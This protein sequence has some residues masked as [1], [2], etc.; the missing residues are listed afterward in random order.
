MELETAEIP[1]CTN[2][3]DVARDGIEAKEKLKGKFY[4]LMVL[5]I[6]LPLSSD[7]DPDPMGGVKLLEE[8]A[9]RDVF[10]KPREVIGLTAFN[11]IR[12]RSNEK[13]SN[14]LWQVLQYDIASNEWLE[15]IKRKVYH[16]LETK[17]A[18]EALKEYEYDVCII[19][20]LK[21]PELKAVLNLQ[22]N[23]QLISDDSDPADYYKGNVFS[24]DGS[25]SYSVVA[26]CAPRMGMT[27]SSILATKMILK[28]KPRYVVMAGI[29]AGVRDKVNLGDVVIADPSWDYGSGKQT[30]SD[31]GSHFHAAPNQISLDP[32]IK[33]RAS[34]LSSD[35][36]FLS[37]LAKYWPTDLPNVV[38]V[39][40]GPVASGA[41][42]LEDTALA[43]HIQS[44]HRKLMGIEMETYGVYAACQDS[45]L[46]QPKAIS[47]KSIC[48]FA[49]S[50]KND[51]YQEYAAYTS[52]SAV[53]ML[54]ERYLFS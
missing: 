13:L 12:I 50:D 46:P 3:I 32:F 18:A 2:N 15:R 6:A 37:E 23:W 45:P 19:T 9:E 52:A 16:I 54:V 29:T 39:H 44:Q 40:I 48:D 25:S 1:E 51:T 11:D 33:S 49:D 42:V 28:F 22:W 4:D 7:Q 14:H 24:Y 21:E 41:A 5:D 34:K 30:L 26:A 8:L 36:E 20:A 35:K 10:N 38:K 53:K 47:L 31:E 43:K 17:G 27:A